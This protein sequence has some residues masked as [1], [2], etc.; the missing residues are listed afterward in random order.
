M[1]D[2]LQVVLD[3]HPARTHAPGVGRYLRELA[4][5]LGSESARF[6][7][8]EC[9]RLDWG[10]A[11]SADLAPGAHG[12]AANL[13]L[14]RVPWPRRLAHAASL[15]GAGPLAG[16]GSGWLHTARL[17]LWPRHAERVVLALSDLPARPAHESEL[18][19]KARAAAA[20]VVFTP[21][22]RERAARNLGVELERVH[23]LPVGCEHWRRDL[24]S[25]P[26]RSEDVLVLGARRASPALTALAQATARLRA[27]GWRGRL[28]CAGRPGSADGPLR[29]LD[30]EESWL[31][32]VEPREVELPE[33]VASA[34]LLAYL[35]P[36]PGTP[37]TPLEALAMGTPL[38]CLR[39]EVLAEVLG[40]APT[41]VELS[42]A[43]DTM[44]WSSAVRTGLATVPDPA[45][46]E[47]VRGHTWARSAREHLRLWRM[48]G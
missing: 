34:G 32:L 43:A 17:D 23:A 29:E 5:A 18:A 8:I 24:A 28:V 27:E 31:R 19:R 25:T 41:W 40:A 4:R 21:L 38:A 12:A 36:D 30:P 3:W 44:A 11:A 39:S 14:R 7:G 22:W 48:I 6:D 10:R 33:L 20:I 45:A 13:P 26:A 15:V 1:A 35:Q 9:R 47:L 46:A 37:V 42:E 16:A 2:A